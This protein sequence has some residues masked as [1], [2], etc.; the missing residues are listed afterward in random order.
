MAV[1]VAV[2]REPDAALLMQ[3]QHDDAPMA[4]GS[5]TDVAW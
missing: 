3:H 1:T 4:D 2:A 5:S